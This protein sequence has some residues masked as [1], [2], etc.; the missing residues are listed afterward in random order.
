MSDTTTQQLLLLLVLSVVT[1]QDAVCH[2]NNG[3]GSVPDVMD[4]PTGLAMTQSLEGCSVRGLMCHMATQC[5][6]TTAL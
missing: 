6:R 3:P 5:T 1:C 2:G 4:H